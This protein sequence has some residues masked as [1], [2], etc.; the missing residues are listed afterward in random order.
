MLPELDQLLTWPVALYLCSVVIAQI[1]LALFRKHKQQRIE[2][3]R[4]AAGLDEKILVDH[5]L[6]LKTL[7]QQSITEVIVLLISIFVFPLLLLLI[8]GVSADG[9]GA[10][11][12]GLLLWALLSATDM[13][14]A[15]LGGIAYKAI[16]AFK[17]PFQVGDRVTLLGQSG[18]IV[19]IGYLLIKLRTSDDELISIPTAAL[20]GQPVL[21]ANAGGRASQCRMDFYLSTQISAELRKKAEDAI[22]DAI[23]RSVYWDFDQPMQIYVAQQRDA[24]VLTAK[25]YVASTYNEPLFRSEVYRAFLDFVDAESIPLPAPE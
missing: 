21:S 8:P 24:I 13:A 7:Q 2:E 25:A 16:I 6:R 22:W 15:F 23:Q 19:E 5:A 14:K 18:K 11:F 4:T 10:A 9:L 12:V 17:N 1:A 20:W 3:K